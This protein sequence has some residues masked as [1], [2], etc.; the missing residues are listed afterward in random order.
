MRELAAQ[1]TCGVSPELVAGAECGPQM[2]PCSSEQD[3]SPLSLLC[4]QP[5]GD[6]R[7]PGESAVWP[8]F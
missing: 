6:P 8:W 1:R 7:W 3:P 4:P 5:W 2:S